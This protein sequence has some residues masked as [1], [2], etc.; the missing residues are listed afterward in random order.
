LYSPYSVIVHCQQQYIG[1]YVKLLNRI[2]PHF[3]V[4]YCNNMQELLI[5]P[6]DKK[7]QVIANAVESCQT[8][9]Q[10]ETAAR[11]IENSYPEDA[12]LIS[13]LTKK[14]NLLYK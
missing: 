1:R 2:L 4:T 9:D 8:L 5:E 3:K 11:L 6:E 12:G 13:A 10:V 14:F 7:L